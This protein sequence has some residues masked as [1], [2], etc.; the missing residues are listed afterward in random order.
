MCPHLLQTSSRQS[1]C[2]L[3]QVS[4]KD[5]VRLWEANPGLHITIA[6]CTFHDQNWTKALEERKGP[7]RESSKWSETKQNKV[8]WGISSIFFVSIIFLCFSLLPASFKGSSLSFSLCQAGWFWFLQFT[9]FNM[10]FFED[11]FQM[12]RSMKASEQRNLGL[13]CIPGWLFVNSSQ[14]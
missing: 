2:S 14:N 9:Y 3:I 5:T 1:R 7:E 11:L 10:V 4:V 13:S 6:M 12:D 8:E